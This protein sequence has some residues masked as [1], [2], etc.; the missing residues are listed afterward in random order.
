MDYHFNPLYVIS[1]RNSCQQQQQQQDQESLS[2]RNNDDRP[3]YLSSTSSTTFGQEFFQSPPLPPNDQ[4][5][6]IYISLVMAGIGFLLPYNSF[7]IAVDYFQQR[8]PDTTIIFDMSAT[9][10]V[11]TFFTVII[12][13]LFVEIIPFRWRLNFGYL[14]SLLFMMFAV[15]WEIWLRLGTY[16]DNL[17]IISIIAVGCSIQQSTFYGYTSMLPKRYVQAVMTGESAAGV[18]VSFNRIITKILYPTEPE[19]N[20]ILFFSISIIVISICAIIHVVILP[21][22]DFIRYYLFICYGNQNNV[23]NNHQ[24]GRLKF[25]DAKIINQINENVNLVNM[26]HRKESEAIMNLSINSDSNLINQ[27]SQIRPSILSIDSQQQSTTGTNSKPILLS[28][29]N[30]QINLQ[31]KVQNILRTDS[32]E[33]VFVVFEFS[34]IFLSFVFFRSDK[35]LRKLFTTLYHK[36]QIRRDII[37]Q[38]W[39]FIFTIIIVYSVTLT[40]FPGI[41]SEIYSCRYGDWFPIILMAIFNLTDF[42]GKLI[43]TLFFRINPKYLL[44]FASI[45]FILIPLFAWS[46]MPRSEPFFS[47][48]FW[49][50]LFSILLG[51]TNGIFGSLPMILAPFKVSEQWREITGNLMT[52]S[53]VI[54]LTAGS[55]A[56]YSLNNWT[57]SSSSTS[58]SNH[59]QHYCPSESIITSDTI[60]TTTTANLVP[61]TNILFNN[62]TLVSSSLSTTTIST[63]INLTTTTTMMMINSITST[64]NLAT[65]TTTTPAMTTTTISSMIIDPSI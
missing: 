17:I 64:L 27:Q 2:I 25:D 59:I 11:I 41:E 42:F 4:Y 58:M 24:N 7:M 56:S 34:L 45:R 30:R 37:K 21:R 53:Y 20:T 46:I 47:N 29:N 43:S 60:E 61:L 19:F 57:L 28:N 13:N 55:F 18:F 62:N 23:D 8:F 36:Y 10:I 52:F 40:I 48:T 39:P 65:T 6:L 44:L 63:P 51:T 14:I 1:D 16:L 38:I 9:Y 33:F 31:T 54:G 32:T 3:I 35:N 50:I 5:G 22:S 12:Q 15:I 26:Y 49:P